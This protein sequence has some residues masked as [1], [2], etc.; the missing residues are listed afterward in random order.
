MQQKTLTRR[1]EGHQNYNPAFSKIAG[2]QHGS[3]KTGRKL[4]G[5]FAHTMVNPSST[6]RVESYSAPESAFES[7]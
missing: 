7:K 4:C 3:L 6:G 1:S 5:R 2:W